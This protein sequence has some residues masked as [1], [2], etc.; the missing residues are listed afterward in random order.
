MANSTTAIPSLYLLKF[1]LALLIVCIHMQPFF[2]QKAIAIVIPLARIGVPSFFMISGYFFYRKYCNRDYAYVR[3]Q[4]LKILKITLIGT[5][6]YLAY[7]FFTNGL[8][9]TLNPLA[10]LKTWR[11]LFLFNVPIAGGHLWYLFAYIYILL[12][13]LLLMKIQISDNHVFILGGV[14]LVLSPIVALICSSF[15][16]SMVLYR[17]WFFTGIPFFLLGMYIRKK[18]IVNGINMNLL[19]ACIVLFGAFSIVDHIL[20][21]NKIH[22][23]LYFA[24]PLLS[25]SLFLV[26][27]KNRNWDMAYLGEI[28][29]RDSLWIY[30]FHILM[31]SILEKVYSFFHFDLA[32]TAY[33]AVPMVLLMSTAFSRLL[34]KVKLFS[35]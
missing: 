15:G 22:R 9:A 5:L 24:T 4:L 32:G 26:F 23:D 2:S 3:R 29:K 7:A 1:V 34:Q 18:D 21:G 31:I 20:V 12:S 14:I 16:I 35:I 25:V 33:I 13:T 6:V 10:T 8:S 30:I 19:I 11:A 17:N 28:G 27:L